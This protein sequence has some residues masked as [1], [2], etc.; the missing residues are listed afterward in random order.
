MGEDSWV[1]CQSCGELHKT[2]VDLSD[3][4]LY[5]EIYCPKCRDR[6]K[7]LRCGKQ[8]DVYMNYNLNVDPRYY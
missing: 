2:K 6:T 4:D 5:I 1:Q 7:H 3:E 8:E